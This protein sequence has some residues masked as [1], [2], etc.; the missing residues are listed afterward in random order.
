MAFEEHHE[1]ILMDTFVDRNQT[2]VNVG[3][4][5]KFTEM[6]L[7]EWRPGVVGMNIDLTRVYQD[8]LWGRT[9]SGVQTCPQLYFMALVSRHQDLNKKRLEAKHTQDD[10]GIKER[11][12]TI[13]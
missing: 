5:D 4:G 8:L 12:L 9:R 6:I 11:V 13:S 2:I 10:G 1:L 3:L 7:R